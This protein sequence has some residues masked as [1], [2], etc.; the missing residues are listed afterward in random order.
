M[1]ISCARRMQDSAVEKGDIYNVMEHECDCHEHGGH[2]TESMPALQIFKRG[3]RGNVT[4]EVLRNLE[5][6]V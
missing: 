6:K 4:A 2:E 1:E 3:L 5:R